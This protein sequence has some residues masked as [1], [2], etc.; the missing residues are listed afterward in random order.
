LPNNSQVTN[1]LISALK[2]TTL[3]VAYNKARNKIIFHKSLEELCI[4]ELAS[5]ELDFDLTN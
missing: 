1:P 3:E 4:S 2:N 5:F